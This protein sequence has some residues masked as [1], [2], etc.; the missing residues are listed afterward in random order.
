MV[1]ETFLPFKG[2]LF[3]NFYP[4]QIL[5]DEDNVFANTEQLFMYRKAL[6]FD[7]EKVAPLLLRETIPK[8]AKALGRMVNGFDQEI[9]NRAKFDIMV[10]CNRLKYM[11]SK[12]NANKLIN[13]YPYTLVEASPWDKIWGVGLSIDDPRVHIREEWLGENLLG[14]ALMV[15]RAELMAL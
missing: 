1:K 6:L 3:S 7:D 13:T 12:H 2:G 14:Q 10:E 4:C 11:K 9:W 8:K 15:V 5:D